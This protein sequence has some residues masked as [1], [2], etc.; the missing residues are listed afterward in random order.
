M[1]EFI[2]KKYDELPEDC[3]IWNLGDVYLSFRLEESKIMNEV[4]RMKK[5]RK[6]CLILGNH[7]FR[8]KKK[9]FSNYVDYFKH[10]GFD[11]VYK[12]PLQF[13]NLI[14]SH[15]PVY[16]E[17]GRELINVHGHTHNVM[18]MEDYFLSEY[19]DGYP[20]EKVNPENYINVC[21]DA[22]KFEILKWKEVE[23]IIKK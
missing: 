8:A 15:E 11:E 2:L 21:L 20:K 1:N 6:M 18:V 7:D 17:K 22:N 13:E 5:N 10:L 16:I 9:P 4:M 19:N 12:E 14:L 23:R 3:L